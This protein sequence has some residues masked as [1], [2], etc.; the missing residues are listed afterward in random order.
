[1]SFRTSRLVLLISNNSEAYA[2]QRAR[3]NKI[4]DLFIE[5]ITEKKS[6]TRETKGEGERDLRQK[7][8]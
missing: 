4:P 2:L 8:S 1:M 6:P 7:G 3:L 5:G